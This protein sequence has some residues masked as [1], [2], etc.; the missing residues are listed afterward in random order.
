[1]AWLYVTEEN[2]EFI[3]G[4]KPKYKKVKV[5]HSVEGKPWLTEWKGEYH[6]YIEHTTFHAVELKKG[7]IRKLIG[8]ELKFKDEAVNFA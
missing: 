4:S 2:K 1:M 6:E 8:R 3:A 7:T 5:V